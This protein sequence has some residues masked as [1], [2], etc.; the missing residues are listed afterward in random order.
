MAAVLNTLEEQGTGS[1]TER[2]DPASVV[3]SDASAPRRRSR[4]LYRFMQ[5]SLPTG[6]GDM[7][8]CTG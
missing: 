1:A 4:A 3:R 2:D 8:P 6:A 5:A 7:S